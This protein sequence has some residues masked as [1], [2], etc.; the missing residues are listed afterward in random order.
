M[1]MV[2]KQPCNPVRGLSKFDSLENSTSLTL[3]LVVPSLFAFLKYYKEKRTEDYFSR[4]EIDVRE[5]E[6][7]TLNGN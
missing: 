4:P 2:G 1:T 3:G 5:L 6:A 7:S